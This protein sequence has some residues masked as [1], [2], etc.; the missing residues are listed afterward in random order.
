MESHLLISWASQLLYQPINSIV[1]GILINRNWIMV[2]GLTLYHYKED[3]PNGSCSNLITTFSILPQ[4]PSYM[5]I[6]LVLFQSFRVLPFFSHH[7]PRMPPHKDVMSPNLTYRLI[8]TLWAGPSP[9]SMRFE[10]LECNHPTS[11][12]SGYYSI[13]RS[14]IVFS[15]LPL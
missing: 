14:T 1:T 2:W 11:P 4:I 12:H 7:S 9:P 8:N 6:T 15:D 5:R 13:W 10:Y 3:A